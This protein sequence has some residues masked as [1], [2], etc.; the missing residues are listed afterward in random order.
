LTKPTRAFAG[1]HRASLAILA[2]LTCLCVSGA[3]DAAERGSSAPPSLAA[4]DWRSGA[5]AIVGRAAWGAGSR[6]VAE[7]SRWLGQANPT[8]TIG[9]WCADFIS[10]RLSR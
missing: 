6:A 3:A 5:P 8:G 1:A 7:A 9:P 10:G 2:T 4:P